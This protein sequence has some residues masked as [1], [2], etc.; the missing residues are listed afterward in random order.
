MGPPKENTFYWLGDDDVLSYIENSKNEVVR[1]IG[2]MLKY[3]RL[4]KV[5]FRVTRE[6]AS[7][8]SLGG[9]KQFSNKYGNPKS[10][11]EL[12]EELVSEIT[13]IT[14]LEDFDTNHIAIYC[15]PDGNMNFKETEVLIRWKGAYP[16]KLIDVEPEHKWEQLIKNEVKAL[17]EKYEALWN[18]HIFIHPKYRGNIYEIEKCCE[19]VLGVG[20]DPLLK[21]SF[22]RFEEYKESL[23]YEKL[24]AQKETEIVTTARGLAR[25]GEAGKEETLNE[26]I[27]QRMTAPAGEEQKEEFIDK[28]VRKNGR[29][30]RK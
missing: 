9:V 18:M 7:D 25:R 28:D 4:F 17:E 22:E 16:T 2:E 27:L 24:L 12:E 19:R 26:A 13:K 29:A 11:V 20:N 23:D 3:R 15:P 6:A 14:G 30:K 1:E 8:S 21:H 5:V 10:R